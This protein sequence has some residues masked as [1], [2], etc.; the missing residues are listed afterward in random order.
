M[1]LLGFQ[2]H[3]QS[4]NSLWIQVLCSC[5]DPSSTY[6]Q[7]HV[8]VSWSRD[9]GSCIKAKLNQ[10]LWRQLLWCGDPCH[11]VFIPTQGKMGH[12]FANNTSSV[13]HRCYTQ[14]QIVPDLDRLK[15][16]QEILKKRRD[17]TLVPP[18]PSQQQTTLHSHEGRTVP[19]KWDRAIGK[20]SAAKKLQWDDAK[21]GDNQ[22]SGA[23][24]L[25]WYD[26]AM[27]TWS[28]VH[29]LEDAFVS[30]RLSTCAS[31]I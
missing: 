23:S 5:R 22:Q 2:Q 15:S 25:A 29:A 6:I 11:P 27:R 20:A 13:L 18:S 3:T 30:C 17:E 12:K 16:L 8:Q 4:R 26:T 9:E 24:A 10:M 31:Q 19:F 14:Y 21:L 28:S 1:C 7:A